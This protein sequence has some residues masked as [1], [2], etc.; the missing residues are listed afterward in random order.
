MV[1]YPADFPVGALTMLLDKVRGRDIPLADLAHGA[2]NVQGYA[3][4][5]IFPGGPMI[6]AVPAGWEDSSND[7]AVLEYA[8]RN[9]VEPP[10]EDGVVR[11]VIPWILVAKVAL[12]ILSGLI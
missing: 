7:E 5:Q 6:A 11:G 4:K 10:A 3:Q 8:I 12:K 9:G 2:W 1:P